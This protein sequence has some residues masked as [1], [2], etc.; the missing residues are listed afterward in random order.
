MEKEKVRYDVYHILEEYLGINK[1][2]IKAENYIMKD[3][4]ADSLD[5]VEIIMAIEDHFKIDIEDESAE[6]MKT[7]EDTVN[8]VYDRINELKQQS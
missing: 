4:G 5:S 1:E 3:L 8:G 2:K 7:V 6:L